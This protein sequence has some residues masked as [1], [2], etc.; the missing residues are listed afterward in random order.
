MYLHNF[1]L[2]MMVDTYL[3]NLRNSQRKEFSI[4]LETNILKSN[5]LV[6]QINFLIKETTIK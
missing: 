1:A 4:N 3:S 2:Y 6:S 5:K